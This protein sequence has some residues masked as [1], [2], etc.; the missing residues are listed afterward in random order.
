MARTLT[1]AGVVGLW[2]SLTFAQAPTVPPPPPAPGPAPLADEP[3]R[4][5]FRAFDGSQEVSSET[6]LRIYQSGSRTERRNI[7]FADGLLVVY[8][9]PLV[10]DVQAVRVHDGAVVNVKWTERLVITRYPDE[11]DRHLEVINFRPRFGALQMTSLHAARDASAYDVAAFTSVATAPSA[12]AA[13]T[14]AGAPL[15]SSDYQL[16]VLPAGRY[17][18]RIRRA[19]PSASADSPEQWMMNLEVPA[20]RTRLRTLEPVEAK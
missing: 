19:A 11:P 1:L 10:Y 3:V 8:L 20:D 13:R 6:H 5:E 18:V 4:C 17:D 14:P 7:D 12:A 16:F 9:P 2:A 15:K